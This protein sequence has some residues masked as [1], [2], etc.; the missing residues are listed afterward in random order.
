MCNSTDCHHLADKKLLYY[1]FLV[2]S[3]IFCL[4]VCLLL[5]LPLPAPSFPFFVKVSSHALW[6]LHVVCHNFKCVC[7]CSFVCVS[8]Y[9]QLHGL[10]PSGLLC[11]LN[12]PGNNTGAGCHFLLQGIVPTQGLNPCSPVS[13][14][15]AGGFFTTKPPEKPLVP[16]NQIAI[17]CCF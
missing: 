13:T 14:T 17:L 6:G 15:L 16:R 2:S 7:V 10:K 4:F 9:L 8:N 5:I 3:N 11:P 1:K 12:F